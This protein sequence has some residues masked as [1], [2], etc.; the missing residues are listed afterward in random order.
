M[1]GADV[2]VLHAIGFGLGLVRHELE[3]R[4]HP[5]LRSAVGLGKLREQ[6]AGAAADRAGVGRHLA[7]EL[8]NDPL[9]LL[10]QGDEQMLGL[11]LRVIHR[12]MIQLIRREEKLLRPERPPEVGRDAAPDHLVE[13]EESE[14]PEPGLARGDAGEGYGN[15]AD[16][17]EGFG[18]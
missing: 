1:L 2:L 10:D 17:Q 6:L 15:D 11:D 14:H 4:R 3:P 12:C 18:P 9:A 5:G 8:G 13:H 16:D 7:Q